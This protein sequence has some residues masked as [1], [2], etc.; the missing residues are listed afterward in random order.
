MNFRS[1]AIISRLGRVAL[2][3]STTPPKSTIPSSNGDQHAFHTPPPSGF[4]YAA[5][6]R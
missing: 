3:P 1:C 5:F 4:S 2:K 6:L